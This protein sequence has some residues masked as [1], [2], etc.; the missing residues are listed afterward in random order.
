MFALLAGM[1][2]VWGCQRTVD[3]PL[4]ISS[5]T[6]T[7]S[8]QGRVTDENKMPVSGAQ[9]KAGSATTT[10]DVNGNF[11][12]ENIALTQNAGL[13]KVEKDG[14]FLGSR[15]LVVKAGVVNKVSIELLEKTNAGSFAAASGGNI[16]LPAGASIS[17]PAA[18]VYNEA[19][20]S[21]YD[22]TVTVS[23]TSIDPTASNIS[24]VMPGDFRGIT[25]ANKETGLESYGILAV[26]LNGSNKEKLQLANGKR[27]TLTFPIPAELRAGA[28]A[29]ISLWYFDESKGMWK[30]EGSATKQGDVYKG[31][32]SHFSFWTV[33]AP[34]ELVDFSA[35]IK[36]QNGNAVG[37][38]EVV[39]K[40]V[41]D[42]S[43]TSGTGYSDA[44][45]NV[46]GKIPANK[47]LRL[48]VRNECGEVLGAQQIGPFTATANIG[49]ITVSNGQ[50]TTVTITGSVTNCENAAVTNGYVNIVIEG[51][52]QRATISNGNFNIT[53]I[54]CSPSAVSAII[55]AF[56]VTE[57][58][59]SEPT[60]IAVTSGIITAPVL[61]ACNEFVSFT[62]DGAAYSIRLPEDSIFASY[63]EGVHQ[64]SS[65][66]GPNASTWS[67]AMFRFTGDTIKGS[68]P[69]VYADFT[70]N[71]RM[72]RRT[73]AI[74][75]TITKYGGIG[76]YVVGNFTGIVADSM[77][78]SITVP[79][80]CDF[81]V[82]RNW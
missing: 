42:T 44:S 47:T 9:V 5:P 56:D 29:T 60:E 46:S 77:N 52:T 65:W 69:I 30:E 21:A 43:V 58:T 45:G 25:A 33:N 34:F 51:K 39:L 53:L 6:V 23:A 68:H 67:A 57:H 70:A 18:G 17:F 61:K 3:K 14:F 41:G 11:K 74:N 82:K 1:V 37:N 54:R 78:L 73:T 32:V 28:P 31:T 36:D 2:I 72:Y 64:V 24:A 80:S 71:G 50:M 66:N 4:D 7:A 79:V 81:R 63:S 19:T 59:Q 40:E 12:F 8:V 38:A 76:E 22:G 49:T 15:T 20:K 75:T 35:V 62:I 10:T 55:T 26:E 16:Q 13:V 27:A 48:T